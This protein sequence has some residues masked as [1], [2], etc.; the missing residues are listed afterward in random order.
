MNNIQRLI[1]LTLFTLI[2]RSDSFSHS[3]IELTDVTPNGEFGSADDYYFVRFI[4]EGVSDLSVSFPSV[5][6]NFLTPTQIANNET[7]A[8]QMD[9]P[10]PSAQDL[11]SDFTT[12][13]MLIS[14]AEM[15]FSG[16]IKVEGYKLS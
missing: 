7:V 9:V 15:Y 12:D 1:A 13:F 6:K 10:F 2:T 16:S 14:R 5:K 3:E 11:G 8:E 4:G